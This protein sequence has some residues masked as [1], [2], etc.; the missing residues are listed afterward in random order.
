VQSFFGWLSTLPDLIQIPLVI[1]VFLVVVG[2]VIFFIEIAPRSG[3]LAVIFAPVFPGRWGPDN[4]ANAAITAP[5]IAFAWITA[6]IVLGAALGGGLFGLWGNLGSIGFLT[7]DLQAVIF[8]QLILTVVSVVLVFSAVLMTLHKFSGLRIFVMT[9]FVWLAVQIV[10]FVFLYLEAVQ[11]GVT[12]L[13][14]GA[15]FGFNMVA[16]GL[17]NFG[18][19][20]F[21]GV[22]LAL[23]AFICTYAVVT[24]C[25]RTAAHPGKTIEIPYSLIRLLVSIGV[26]TC[27]LLV[28]GVK[29][30]NFWSGAF[31][32]FLLGATLGAVLFWL[33]FKGRNGSGYLIQLLLFLSP[34][35]ALVAVGLIWP[36]VKTIYAAFMTNTSGAHFVGLANFAWVFKPGANGGLPSVI[37]TIVWVL[38]AP[39]VT[40][41]IGTVYAVLVDKT[42]W[43]KVLK[44]FIF[45]PV[46]ISLV[47]ASVIWKFFYNYQQGKVQTG[48]LNQIV[49]NLG[50]NPVSWFQHYPLNVILLILI[51]VW[52][53]TG[54]A[55]VLLSTAIKAVPPEEHE[56]ASLDGANAWQRFWSITIPDIKPTL[57]VVWTTVSMASLKVYDIIAATTGGEN[58]TSVLGYNM[59]YQYNM[60][61][62]QVGR[63]SAIAVLIFILVLPFLIYNAHNLKQQRES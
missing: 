40:V 20:Q 7:P 12:G 58:D 49:V 41:A 28:L 63:A 9:A 33:D 34:A 29:S 26:P 14:V 44:V 25:N 8:T 23:L 57:I 19:W 53:Q 56:A 42:R 24:K 48:L 45:M 18:Y 21:L 15:F 52:S 55:M 3:K 36:S 27:V 62:P 4:N 50:G 35:L 30:G 47:G 37:N 17:V 38:I 51:L 32:V 16:S 59:V 43:E 2:I 1:G 11:D 31:W 54:F 61:P 13:A 22:T 46:A 39:V 5:S 10:M 6:A 60:L